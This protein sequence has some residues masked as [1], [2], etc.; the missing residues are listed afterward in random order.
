MIMVDKRDESLLRLTADVVAAHVANNSVA[1]GDIA[2]LVG[3]VHKAL[4][5]LGRAAIAPK[6]ELKPA[7]SVRTSVKPDYIV[8]LEDGRKLKMLKRHLR[9]DHGLSPAEYRAKWGL[10]E[11]Y[12]MVASAYAETRRGLALKI[13]LGRK[14][15]VISEPAEPVRKPRAAKPSEA[16]IPK[17][18]RRRAV[19]PAAT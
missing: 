2:T 9:T 6:P 10:P 7:V 18:S 17:A 3:N 14:K 16:P 8:C 4:S 15:A 1:V 5:G 12:P 13:G 19:T 11:A